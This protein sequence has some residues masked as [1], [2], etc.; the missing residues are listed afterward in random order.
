MAVWNDSEDV[1]KKRTKNGGVCA[2][3]IVAILTTE[4]C[5]N[6]D[7]PEVEPTIGT[8]GNGDD[9]ADGDGADETA[10]PPVAACWPEHE[11]TNPT[12]FQ[13]VG[14]AVGQLDFIQCGQLLG[15]ETSIAGICD[16]NDVD[17]WTVEPDGPAD[18]IPFPPEPPATDPNA[19]AC[20]ESNA[21]AAQTREGCLSDCARAGCNKAI[22]DLETA[23]ANHIA[24]P[25]IGCGGTTDCFERVVTGLE[26]WI[27]FLDTHYEDCV[28]SVLIDVPFNFPNPDVDAGPGAIACGMLEIDCTLDEEADPYDLEQTCSTSENEPQTATGM[29]L[30][31]KLDGAVEISG[32]QGNDFTTLEGTAIVHRESS[33]T[34]ESCWFHITSLELDADDFSSG[35]YIGLDMHA[36]LAYE[37]FGMFDESTG[38]GTIAPR[39]LGLD[40][41]MQGKEPSTS[42]VSYAFRMANS[43]PV[44]LE[45]TSSQLE[46][47]DA[48][49]AW[50]DHDLVITTDLASCTCLNCS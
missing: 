43:D 34:T 32:P 33:C 22:A 18:P 25:P 30:E 1:M 48:Y 6:E 42:F 16:F 4:A 28:A 39:M 17:D 13:C 38:D 8:G 46:I 27:A 29:M 31:C 35:G 12:L 3:V 2:A 41:T 37:G 15:C 20:C 40:V 21:N 50:K 9:D 26:T 11:P 47:V 36:T 23:L 44:F 5:N 45:T 10:L 14:E 49:F 24:N 19:Q 7:V